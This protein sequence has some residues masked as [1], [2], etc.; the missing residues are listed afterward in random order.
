MSE[1]FDLAV[2]G[3]GPAGSAAAWQAAQ[4]GANVVVLDKAD[5]P[6][7]KPCGDGLTAR[8]VRYLHRMGLSGEL[9]AAVAEAGARLPVDVED[10][11]ARADEPAVLERRSRVEDRRAR[12]RREYAGAPG[13]A[14][15]RNST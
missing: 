10:P 6:R 2:V 8:A 12:S 7:D 15:R 9:F 14:R 11:P 4:A 3:G 5:F 1:R 13:R